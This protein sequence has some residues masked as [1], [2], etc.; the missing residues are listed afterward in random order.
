MSYGGMCLAEVAFQ[1]PSCFPKN[2]DVI[3]EKQLSTGVCSANSLFPIQC[4]ANSSVFNEEQA[5]SNLTSF[6]VEKVMI[7]DPTIDDSSKKTLPSSREAW[8]QLKTRTLIGI[9]IP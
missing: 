9:L 8:W 1:P 4:T 6:S 7:H 2:F 5:K 3:F